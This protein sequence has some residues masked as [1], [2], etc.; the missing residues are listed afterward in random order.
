VVLYPDI[1]GTLVASVGPVFSY[2]EFPLEGVEGGE[3]PRLNDD[4]WKKKLETEDV[5]GLLPNWVLDIYGKMEPWITPEF[6]NVAIILLFT[7]VTLVGTA[8]TRLIRKS[9]SRHRYPK[10][11]KQL[12]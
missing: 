9:S 7:S 5:S 11:L 2:Y 3:L 12:Y 4:E 10:I 6:G 1:N 8:A